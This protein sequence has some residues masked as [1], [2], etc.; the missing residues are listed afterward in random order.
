MSSARQKFKFRNI[1]HEQQSSLIQLQDHIWG[2]YAISSKGSD[3]LTYIHGRRQR[4][5]ESL[6]VEP[7]ET[8]QEKE[9]SEDEDKPVTQKRLELELERFRNQL[10]SERLAKELKRWR[11]VHKILVILMIVTIYS[12]LFYQLIKWKLAP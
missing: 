9:M 1:E 3:G 8:A 2:T 6:L 4:P 12:L 7:H 10:E 5:H 11:C